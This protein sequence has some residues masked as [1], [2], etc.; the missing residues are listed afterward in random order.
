M[1]AQLQAAIAADSRATTMAG[2][3][4]TLALAVGAAGVAWFP[5][6]RGSA[7]LLASTVCA[8]ILLLAAARAAWAARPID[9]YFPGNQPPQWW[10]CRKGNLAE[11][12]GGESE[13]YGARIEY[14]QDRLTENQ[15][16]IKD[17]STLALISPILGAGFALLAIYFSSRA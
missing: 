7:Y 2:M 8:A 15:T 14:N 1:S 17:A 5:D 16:A 6:A 12:L 3:F 9:F 4:I 13:N 11:L 10:P